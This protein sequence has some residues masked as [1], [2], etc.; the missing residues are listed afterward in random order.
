MKKI[1]ITLARAD[2]Q[3]IDE[4]VNIYKSSLINFNSETCNWEFHSKFYQPAEILFKIHSIQF[5]E[6][7]NVENYIKKSFEDNIIPKAFAAAKAVKAISK[8]PNDFQYVDP[9]AKIIDKV[10]Q[11][12][13]IYSYKEQWSVF[14]FVTD[15]FISVLNSH[16][17]KNGNKRFSFSLLK[18][19]LF[20]FG[21]YFK[22]SSNVKNSSFLEEYNKNIENEIACF[23]F[24]LSNAK[25]AD[26]FENSQDFKNQNPTC[27]KKLSKEKELDIKERQE[28]TRTEIKKWLLNKIIIGY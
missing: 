23:E 10:K 8:D 15:I 26:L 7:K 25:I 5:N 20:D 17:L 22:W 4:F 6:M 1:N 19:M 12:V 2:F 24:Q 16:L 14:D 3:N 18:V 21:F 27:F 28:K 11:V 13:N 9:N